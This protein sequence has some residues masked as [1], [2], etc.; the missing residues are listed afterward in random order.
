MEFNDFQF[1]RIEIWH[2]GKKS[3]LIIQFLE[4][5]QVIPEIFRLET[6]GKVVH[7]LPLELMMVMNT[8]G[9]NDINTILLVTYNSILRTF[10]I[11]KGASSIYDQAWI[12]TLVVLFFRRWLMFNTLMEE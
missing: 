10:P 9:D 5:G 12:A 6:G 3:F 8:C 7:N 1:S 2:K 11:E 4:L